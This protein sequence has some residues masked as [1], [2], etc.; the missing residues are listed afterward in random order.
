MAGGGGLVVP[1][2][3]LCQ[4]EVVEDPG[5]ARPCTEVTIYLQG[6][7][8]AGCSRRGFSGCQLQFAEVPGKCRRRSGPPTSPAQR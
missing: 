6:L 1:G 7:Q 2:Q 3:L 4:A 8:M 5:L